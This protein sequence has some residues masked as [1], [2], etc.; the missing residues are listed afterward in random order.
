M[1]GCMDRRGE[2]PFLSFFGDY[3]MKQ[4]T[5][6]DH[7]N[8]AEILEIL[9]DRKI[10]KSYSHHFDDDQL[11]PFDATAVT[12]FKDKATDRSYERMI[13]LELRDRSKYTREQI[14]E[15]GGLCINAGNLFSLIH[16]ARANETSVY[17]VARFANNEIAFYRLYDHERQQV[18]NQSYH[19]NCMIPVMVT[20]G[21]RQKSRGDDLIDTCPVVTL[22]WRDVC[23]VSCEPY[24]DPE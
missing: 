8:E 15:W 12:R 16:R 5:S 23:A 7:A 19:Q 4:V 10:I 18:L 22:T 11:W 9:K 14:D 20:M 24:S 21:K 1:L 6:Q 13:W 3:Q 17:F 2:T